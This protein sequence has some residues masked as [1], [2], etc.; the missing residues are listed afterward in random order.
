MVAAARANLEPILLLYDGQGGTDEV[1]AKARSN[2]PL[3]DITALDGTSH[4]LWSITA[5]ETL[6]EI[7]A[8]LKARQALIADGHHR[9]A[10]Y[11]QLRRHHRAVGGAARPGAGV[12]LP[13]LPM[14]SYYDARSGASGSSE[15]GVGSMGGPG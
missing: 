9:Y 2:E 12:D 6:R 4:R 1:I 10:T 3:M 5:P 7:K 11:R 13:E 15:G 8:H 14:L